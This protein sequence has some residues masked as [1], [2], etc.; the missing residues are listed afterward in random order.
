MNDEVKT[1]SPKLCGFDGGDKDGSQFL[2]F[3]VQFRQACG[4]NDLAFGEK[5]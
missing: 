5:V 4:G 3:T 2:R 1:S